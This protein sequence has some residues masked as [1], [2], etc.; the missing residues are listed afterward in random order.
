MIAGIVES[1]RRR[2]FDIYRK[3]ETKT[4]PL[5]SVLW[6]CTLRCNLNCGHCGSDCKSSSETPDAD[7]LLFFSALDDI[8]RHFDPASVMIGITGGEPLMRSDLPSIISEIRSRGFPAGMVSNGFALSPAKFVELVNSGLNSLTISMDGLE[9]EHNALRNHPKSFDNAMMAIRN[10][11]KFVSQSQGRTPFDFDVVTCVNPDNFGSLP[12]IK[13][14]LCEA[15]VRNWRLFSVFPS[16]RAGSGKYELSRDEYRGMLDF[17]SDARSSGGMN[18]SYS[19][20]GWLGDY[21]MKTR[22][23]YYFCRAGI[24]NAGIFADGSVGGCISARSN[25]FIIGNLHD[26]PFMRIWNEDFGIFRDRSWTKRGMCAECGE[27]RHCA[28]NGIH[29]Y[30]SLRCGPSRCSLPGK[31]GVCDSGAGSH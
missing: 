16:G 19:C 21:E 5:R 14:M 9:E 27:Y 6:E 2:L 22:G 11:A 24:T 23:S 28:G 18:V 8:A 10:A 30:S 15:G 26:K 3:T 17:I 7:A 29:L 13:R 25:D 4:H 20:E 12:E 1:L 31:F